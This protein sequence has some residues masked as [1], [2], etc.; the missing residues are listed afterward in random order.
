MIQRLPNLSKQRSFFLFGPRSTGKSTLLQSWSADLS[1]A[2]YDLL[3]PSTESQLALRPDLILER[4]QSQP[5]DWIGI[6]EV[7]KV[8]KI[9][10]VVQTG[11]FKHRI[12]FALTASSA[13]KLRRGSANLLGGRATEF[14]LHPLTSVELQ[15]GF[16][17]QDALSWGTLP[18]I[19]FL[20]Q[21][22]K[23]R[24]LCS[25]LSTYLKEEVLVEQLVRKIETFRK[26]LE[27][28]SQMNGHI[29]NYAKI[30]KDSGIQ[31]RSVGRYY[32]ILSDTLLG[33]FLEPF[34]HSIRKRQ[35]QKAKFYF[36]DTGVV[37][38]LQNSVTLPLN[39]QTYDYGDV[40]EHFVLLEIFRLNDYLEKR[41]K[42][43]YLRT[44][45]QVEVDLIIERPGEPLLLVEVKS[46]STNL[47]QHA[48]SLKRLWSDFPKAKMMIL[49]NSTQ[50]MVHEDIL[51]INWRD[52]LHKV[53]EIP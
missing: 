42:F 28:S 21:A 27:I 25:Y 33:F 26:F 34:E 37:R 6:D 50:S 36:F 38:A 51:F 41:F 47:L 48:N 4:W 8:P 45:D 11:I 52:G 3:D 23:V 7:Q 31:E 32:E 17:L 19:T 14:R 44:K 16:Q 29:L 18:E 40:F 35:I 43:S 10:D 1:I 49:N 46:G 13:R 20:P 24:A 2:T 5:T 30:G 15:D 12:K 39:E 9:L 53:F 22:E